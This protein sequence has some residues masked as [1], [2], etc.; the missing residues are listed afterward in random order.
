MNFSRYAK[1]LVI[2]VVV[3]STSLATSA[4]AQEGDEQQP[5]KDLLPSKQDPIAATVRGRLQD[6]I[7]AIGGETTGTL[8]TAAGLTW[9][10]DLSKDPK[11]RA[12]AKQQN[13]QTV[14]ARGFL[15]RVKGVEVPER[16]IVTVDSLEAAPTGAKDSSIQVRILG[17]LHHGIQQ[18]G[19]ETT[20]TV[21]LVG[22]I[23]FELDLSHKV[24]L[25][26]VAEKL[27]KQT[28]LCAG[29]LR[30]VKGIEVPDRLVIQAE[31]LAEPNADPTR[32][33]R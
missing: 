3:G 4:V 5:R 6:G 2:L 27:N 24:N 22:E 28:V 32:D 14:V 33:Q 29:S 7:M 17:R 30:R 8:I 15:K 10:L 20:G 31:Q 13:K 9:E 21:V 26:S 23:P 1:S 25:K 18:V 19:G 12:V 11:F 16:W